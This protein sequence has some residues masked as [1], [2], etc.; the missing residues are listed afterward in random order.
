MRKLK[1]AQAFKLRFNKWAGK[2]AV[3]DPVDTHFNP[4]GP[5]ALREA[6]AAKS[7]V[8]DAMSVL[9]APTLGRYNKTSGQ[10]R[11]IAEATSR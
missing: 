9:P 7:K 1:D 3:Q 8:F 5:I 4:S 10:L 6:E 11:N 2:S